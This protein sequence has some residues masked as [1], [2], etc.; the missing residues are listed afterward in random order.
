MADCVAEVQNCP[1][2]TFA[3]VGADDRGLNRATPFD[4]RGQCGGLT[5][6]DPAVILFQPRKKSGI[7]NRRSFNYLGKAGAQFPHWQ[8]GQE[9]G[10]RQD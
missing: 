3:F 4:S 2:P 7:G 9:C 1:A 6:E 5:A 8:S 10:V